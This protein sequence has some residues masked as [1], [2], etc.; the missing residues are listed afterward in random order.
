MILRYYSTPDIL[1]LDRE[2][3]MD[4]QTYENEI[5]EHLSLLYPGASIRQ[6]VQLLGRYSQ[7]S[8]Q[9]DVLIEDDIAGFKTRVVVDGKYFSRR[10]D[11]THIDS[12]I[13][14][15][16][17]VGAT[18]G[19][20]VTP[21]GYT[22]AALRRAHNHTTD[23]VLDVL[24]LS[25][26]REYQNFAGIPYAGN[27]A[28]WVTAPFGWVVDFSRR[29]GFLATLYQRGRTLEEAKRAHEWMYVNYW[30][31]DAQASTLA[32]VMNMQTQGMDIA[33]ERLETS[34]HS[35]PVR[36]DG[37]ATRVRVATYDNKPFKEITGYIDGDGFVAFFVLFTV[38]ELERTNT[39]KLM[40][41]LKYSTHHEIEFRNEKVIR[42]LSGSVDS[43]SDAE[44]KAAAYTQIAIWYA[45][46]DDYENATEYYRRSFRTSPT[47]YRNFEPLMAVELRESR[48]DSAA[49]CARALFR[50]DPE[51]PRAMQD[52]LTRY[53][54]DKYDSALGKL[55]LELMEEHKGNREAEVNIGFHYGLRLVD[56]GRYEAAVPALREA[57]VTAQAISEDHP[58]L[59]GIEQMLV[60][61]EQGSDA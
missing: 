41:V 30:R 1:D 5:Y 47:V 35:G 54:R 36:D 8:R 12:F 31:K 3:A 39:R 44:E 27:K 13:G 60:A 56:G 38:P 15:L 45:E 21:H 61:I 34:D 40:H 51:N 46:M 59:V 23:V 49:E 50:L 55:V 33:Y 17:D 58:A 42:A 9:I 24:N 18:H 6:D 32:E 22:K 10:L 52:I 2:V 48:M 57:R 29:D 16:E 53:G 7:R 26:F 25:E 28:M 14:L 19:L 37:R 11:V 20:L 43:M 4:W